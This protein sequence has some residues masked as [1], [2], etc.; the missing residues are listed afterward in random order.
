MI[1]VAIL[2]G[3]LGTRFPEETELKPKPMIPIGPYPIIWHIMK[4]FSCFGFEDFYVATGYKSDVLKSYFVDYHKLS[5]N[6]EVDLATGR[7][8]NYA[9]P[10]EKWRVR[11]IETGLMTETGGRIRRMKEWLSGPEPFI[12]TYGDGVADIDVQAL[13]DFH[14]SHGK[15]VTVTTVRPPARFGAIKMDGLR[16][17]TFREKSQTVEGW[18]NGGFLVFNEGIF[19]YLKHDHDSLEHAVLEQ[20]AREGE[21]MAYRHEGFWQCMDA[22]RDKKRLEELWNRGDPPW[23]LWNG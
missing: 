23:K 18:I 15:L 12:V 14:R 16:V 3:G 11:L 4:I 10:P 21:L 1:K 7:V 19:D 17:E 5:G 6:I 9:N 13:L 20:L 22:P 8:V 2:A